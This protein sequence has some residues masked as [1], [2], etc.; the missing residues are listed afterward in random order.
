M[1]L[2]RL[3]TGNR[4]QQIHPAVPAEPRST[5]VPWSTAVSRNTAVV[6]AVLGGGRRFGLAQ[7]ARVGRVISPPGSKQERIKPELQ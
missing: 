4:R 6:S 2:S 7:I 5:A 3:G 1:Y